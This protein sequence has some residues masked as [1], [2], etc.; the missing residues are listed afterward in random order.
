MEVL[1]KQV[2]IFWGNFLGGNLLKEGLLRRGLNILLVTHHFLE[3]QNIHIELELEI[4][5]GVLITGGFY[6][7]GEIKRICLVLSKNRLFRIDFTEALTGLP[8]FDR[9]DKDCLRG[10]IGKQ[11]HG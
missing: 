7:R 4:P 6:L 10:V 9:V 8:Y 1:D 11:R 5:W 3:R 2:K